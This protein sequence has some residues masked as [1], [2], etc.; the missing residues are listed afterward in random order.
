MNTQEKLILNTMDL[1]RQITE[2]KLSRRDLLKMGMLSATTGMLLP[3]SGLSLRSAF[4][5]GGNNSSLAT[6]SGGNGGCPEPGKDIISPPTRP[7]IEELPRLV[8]KQTVA[9]NDPNSCDHGNGGGEIGR[10]HV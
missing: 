8:E 10:A 5:K 9:G 1:H 4:A 3:I 6:S 2:A 7:W